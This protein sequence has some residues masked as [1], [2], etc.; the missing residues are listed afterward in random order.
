MAEDERIEV[1]RAPF[2]DRW[3]KIL[4]VKTRQILERTHLSR[5]G[6]PFRPE[7]YV[8][9]L[10]DVHVLKS[11]ICSDIRGLPETDEV[12]EVLFKIQDILVPFRPEDYPDEN[13]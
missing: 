3:V 5:W 12:Q 6:D 4:V 11:L 9:T 1:G 7:D 2:G 13:A 10:S 8:P